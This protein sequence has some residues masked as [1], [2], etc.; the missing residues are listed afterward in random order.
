MRKATFLTA[1]VAL[2]IVGQSCGD[3][4]Q[5][6]PA[7]PPSRACDEVLPRSNVNYDVIGEVFHS[8]R[9]RL[10]SDG[11]LPEHFAE[12]TEGADFLVCNNR[13]Y[14][15]F[16]LYSDPPVVIF[17]LQMIGFMWAQARSMVLG[18]YVAERVASV[19]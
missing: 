13:S 1:A 3:V 11:L 17:D 10:E 12:R 8:K 2:L 7:S 19:R 9:G 5:Q 6:E 4:T 16:V 15:T 18:Q 14:G